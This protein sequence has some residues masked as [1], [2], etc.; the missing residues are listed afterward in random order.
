[1][2]T[3]NQI[4]EAHEVSNQGNEV[5]LPQAALIAGFD[6]PIGPVILAQLTAYP[7]LVI[8]GSADEPARNP[9]ARQGMFLASIFCYPTTFVIEVVIAGM[10]YLLLSPTS[11][12]LSLL[13]A[14]FRSV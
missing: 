2:A 13:T 6:Y 12:S 7:K 4:S 8:P 10:L 1:M 14:W 9:V 11:G 3:V 5:S